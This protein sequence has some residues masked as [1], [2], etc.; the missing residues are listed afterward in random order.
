MGILGRPSSLPPS[1]VLL[2]QVG[3]GC[4][5]RLLR[6]K[7]GFLCLRGRVSVREGYE[8]SEG[9]TG[10]GDGDEGEKIVCIRGDVRVTRETGGVV[11]V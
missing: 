11:L 3:L 9:K 8:V 10:L 1:S 6:F 5:Q 7:F 4:R 2:R